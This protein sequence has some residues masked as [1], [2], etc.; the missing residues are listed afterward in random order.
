MNKDNGVRIGFDD[1]DSSAEDKAWALMDAASAAITHKTTVNDKSGKSRGYSLKDL[2]PDTNGFTRGLAYLFSG[3]APKTFD[4]TYD[5]AKYG[6]QSVN[7]DDSEAVKGRKR[8]IN[9]NI[10][11]NIYSGAYSDEPAEH[12][13]RKI[14]DAIQRTPGSDGRFDWGD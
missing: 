6:W 9:R 1:I 4:N 10:V 7:D 5:L 11:Q 12:W 14:E 8:L 2:Y 13:K 3:G